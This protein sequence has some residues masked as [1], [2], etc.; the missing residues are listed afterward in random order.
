MSEL[1]AQDHYN[2]TKDFV[3]EET[4]QF[5]KLSSNG[6]RTETDLESVFDFAEVYYTSRRE[7][8][9][10]HIGS[11]RPN[12]EDYDFNDEFQSLKYGHDLVKYADH[13]EFSIERNLQEKI[14]AEYN[15]FLY[16]SRGTISNLAIKHGI[17][18]EHLMSFLLV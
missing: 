17:T 4:R 7:E 3:D 2:N 5:T 10:K 1:K 15:A 9:T 14:Q 8:A 13:L 18:I 12:R 11:K 16:F 6:S